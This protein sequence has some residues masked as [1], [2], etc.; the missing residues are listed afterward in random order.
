MLIRRLMNGRYIC[1]G[2]IARTST[3]PPSSKMGQPLEISVAP[4]R[5]FALTMRYPPTTS[6]D[7]TNGP[8]VTSFFVPD[9][10]FPPPS[11]GSPALKVPA[12]TRLCIHAPHFCSDRCI[13]SGE[14]VVPGR[15]P[16]NRS[17]KSFI[18]AS[19]LIRRTRS[20]PPDTH[21]SRRPFDVRGPGHVADAV[22]KLAE[23]RLRER[24]LGHDERV[25]I[26]RRHAKRAH[27]FQSYRCDRL[28]FT[29]DERNIAK[30][31]GWSGLPDLAPAHEDADTALAEHVERIGHL[32]VAQKCFALV[33]R[34]WMRHRGEAREIVAGHVGEEIG[35]LENR[36]RRQQLVQLRFV[37]RHDGS[38]RARRPSGVILMIDDDDAQPGLGLQQVLGGGATE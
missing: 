33:E 18:T 3:D 23:H 38:F 8:S 32:S 34:P 37:R 29:I 35:S 27:L 17:K 31:V 12:V 19:H 15:P 30:A 13:S 9:T 22:S 20:S 26:E 14:R 6:L 24:G 1:T 10:I 7:S 16:R 25:E 2:L 21:D 28:H 5:F 4:S 36:H 11:S